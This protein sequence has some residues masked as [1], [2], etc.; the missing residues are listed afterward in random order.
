M[1]FG[2]HALEYAQGGLRVFPIWGVGEDGAC[3]CPK[4]VACDRT[5]KHPQ[6]TLVPRGLLEATDEERRVRAWWQQDPN[7]NIGIATGEGLVVIDLDVG[8]DDET[9]P[10]QM[11]RFLAGQ[12]FPETAAARTGSGGVH[13]YLNHDPEI[14]LRTVAALTLHDGTRYSRIDIRAEGGYVVA[15]PSRHR[16]GHAYHWLVELDAIACA[17]DWLLVALPRRAPGLEAE[18]NALPPPGPIG[19]P[20]PPAVDL[21]APPIDPGEFARIQSALAAIPPNVSHDDWKLRV[22]GALHDHFAGSLVGFELWDRWSASA[23]SRQDWA[24]R[25]DEHGRAK[26]MYPGRRTLMGAWRSFHGNHPNPKG[27]ASLFELARQHGW[28][29]PAGAVTSIAPHGLMAPGM[30]HPLPLGAPPPRPNGAP[31]LAP[32]PP[33]PGAPKPFLSP[34]EELWDSMSPGWLLTDPPPRRYL[35]RQ[36]RIEDGRVIPV[37]GAGFLPLGKAVLL[38]AAGAVGKTNALIQL[39]MCVVTGRRWFGHFYVAT[40]VTPRVAVFLA[41]EDHEEVKRRFRQ[42]AVSLELDEDELRDADR[43]ITAM[44]MFGTEP[45][46]LQ[47]DRFG[48]VSPHPNLEALEKM[49][50]ERGGP[51]GWSLVVLEP[52]SRLSGVNV[53]SDNVLATKFVQVIERLTH[54]RGNPTVLIAGHSSKTARRTGTVDARGV[55]GITDAVRC[56]LTLAEDDE[57]KTIVFAVGKNNYGR[58][59]DPVHLLMDDNHHLFAESEEQRLSRQADLRSAKEARSAAAM[60]ARDEGWQRKRVENVRSIL[61]VLAERGPQSSKDGITGLARLGKSPGRFAIETAL[62]EQWVT[63]SKLAKKTWYQITDTGRDRL[64]RS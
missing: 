17:P 51:D 1:P 18:V 42:A 26:A 10:K 46:L 6:S 27:I 19:S 45:A 49:L 32:P 41:E 53:E 7:A 40:D 23:Q 13:L 38:S 5:G 25:L 50:D 64:N 8:G 2:D 62:T 52:Q 44:G 11:D 3:L 47:G 28:R 31:Q 39:A 14:L 57:S 15:P 30:T 12:V 59:M 60:E 35:L 55:T 56:H 43:K 24:W 29:E 48:A 22:G 34:Y 20:P 37:P 16:S 54:T 21:V 58:R 63:T 36:P 61:R 9:G 33:P 4:G